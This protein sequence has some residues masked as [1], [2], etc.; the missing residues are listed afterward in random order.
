[1]RV[2]CSVCGR[3]REDDAAPCQ[4]CGTLLESTVAGES[5]G[6]AGEL[7]PRDV[8]GGYVIEATV[9]RG[10]MGVVYRARDSVL[11][12]VVALKVI[13]PGLADEARFRQ[14]FEQEWRA[15]ARLE[16]PNIVPVYRAGEEEGRLFLAMRFVEGVDLASVLTDRGRLAP[17]EAVEL[18][19]QVASAL[20][21]AHGGGLVHRDVKP[22]NVL[23]AG[24]HAFLTD[25]GVALVR[26]A[27]VRLTRSGHL[28][29][30]VAYIAPEQIRGANVDG[31][32]DVYAL[33][34]VLYHCLTGRV[35]FPAVS[36]LDALAAHLSS[37]PPRPSRV[38]PDVSA[39]FDRVVGRAMA[40]APTDRYASAGDLAGAAFAAL[41]RQPLPHAPPVVASGAVGRPA[42]MRRNGG[43]A[44]NGRRLQ[45]LGVAAAVLLAVAAS[46]LLGTVIGG[47][48]G[49]RSVS[50]TSVDQA[51]QL[52]GAPI[53]LH[54]QPDRVVFDGARVWTLTAAGGRLARADPRSGRVVYFPAPFDLGGGEFPDLGWGVGSLWVVHHAPSVGGIDRVDPRAASAVAHFPLPSAIA[55]AVGRDAIWAVSDA[56][57]R[58]LRI[59]PVRNRA[60]GRPVPVGRRPVD[61]AVS[62]R[63]VWVAD[64]A[65]DRAL[66]VDPNSDRVIARVPVGHRP[67]IVVA[68]RQA[69]WVANLGDQ[70][71]SSIDPATNL[72]AGAPVTLGKEIQDLALTPRWLWVAAADGTVSRLDRLTGDVRG[73]AVLVAPSP[74]A[75]GADG[76]GVWVASASRQRVQ[77]VAPAA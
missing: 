36:E 47:G 22:A 15:A 77:L 9:G 64:A 20:D 18:I 51:G 73:T 72:P 53:A 31:R 2:A 65:A 40:K 56:P 27:D 11:D 60:V 13:A 59:D 16:H 23:L 54:G 50:S 8:L 75:V 52:V 24:D 3:L 34:G 61:V 76:E 21:A 30:T 57:A 46:V 26:D 62:G 45:M 32:T 38:V 4:A 39:A 66:R 19:G 14:R 7:S 69:V 49:S 74:L 35:P 1:M 25:F 55:V 5:T 63:A 33:G 29:G 42:R 12:R 71:L 43:A 6:F 68:D 58:L 44:I 17:A 28:V 48:G 37:P 70:T 10:G 67:G 41:S